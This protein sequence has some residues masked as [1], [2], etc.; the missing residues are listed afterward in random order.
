M[1]GRADA[2]PS[3]G[4]I[5]SASRSVAASTLQ[6]YKNE[7]RAVALNAIRALGIL[8]EG[9]AEKDL[10]SLTEEKRLLNP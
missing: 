5:T 8:Q 7:R 6:S 4:N 3:S 1:V 2:Q 10:R 9:S